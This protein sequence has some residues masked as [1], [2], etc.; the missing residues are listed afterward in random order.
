MMP[1]VDLTGATPEDPLTLPKQATFWL[2]KSPKPGLVMPPL[3]CPPKD[4]IELGAPI[5][6][7][8]NKI[9]IVDNRQVDYDALRQARAAQESMTMMEPVTLESLYTASDLWLEMLSLTNSVGSFL[10]HSPGLELTTGVYDLFGTVLLS[11]N[12]DGLNATNWAWMARTQPGQTNVSLAGLGTPEGFFRLGTMQDSDGDG[13]TDAYENLTLHSD[14]QT[15]EVA[16]SGVA[17]EKPTTVF[18]N[19]T[20]LW[21]L[22]PKPFSQVP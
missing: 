9:Y 10:L 3:P 2:L 6:W 13:W 20:A 1:E 18:A 15:P 7:I 19:G 4:L 11:A 12:V 8:T 14:P 21:I 5:Y 17:A 22:E 16:S